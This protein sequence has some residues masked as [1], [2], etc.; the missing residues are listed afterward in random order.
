MNATTKDI[1]KEL[2]RRRDAIRVF[3]D[4]HFGSQRAFCKATDLKPARVSKAL[5]NR[6]ISNRRLL[7]LEHAIKQWKRAHGATEDAQDVTVP[8]YALDGGRL[9]PRGEREPVGRRAVPDDVNRDRLVYV[10]VTFTHHAV[11]EV[12]DAKKA[13]HGVDVAA[14]HG[15]ARNAT[16]EYAGLTGGQWTYLT[17]RFDER[18]RPDLVNGDPE[19]VQLFGRAV[20]KLDIGK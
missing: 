19:T 7:P 2:S 16:L 20:M 1:P 15:A 9:R 11:L 6:Y 8:V 10:D 18:G 4:R 3:I 14:V 12:V 13:E 17:V 5:Q